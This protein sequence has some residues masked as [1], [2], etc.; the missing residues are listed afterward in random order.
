MSDAAYWRCDEC[1]A[2]VEGV[3]VVDPTVP[4]RIAE[5]R[6]THAPALSPRQ[7]EALAWIRRVGKATRTTLRQHGY[8]ERTMTALVRRGLATVEHVPTTGGR[9]AIPV[10]RPVDRSEGATPSRTTQERNP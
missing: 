10:W 9:P 6:A 7:S 1:G 4:H 5:H 3:A 2:V 8:T